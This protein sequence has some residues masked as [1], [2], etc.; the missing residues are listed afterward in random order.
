MEEVCER[1]S[2]SKGSPCIQVR[3]SKSARVA[4]F[5]PDMLTETGLGAVEAIG[6]NAADVEVRGL[7]V[8]VEVADND[9]LGTVEVGCGTE[10]V[11]GIEGGEENPKVNPPPEGFGAD[12]S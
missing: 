2:W 9:C 8:V 11:C 12:F 10:I 7:G 6:G 5:A 3:L 1:A 4:G